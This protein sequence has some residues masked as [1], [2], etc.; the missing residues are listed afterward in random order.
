MYRQRHNPHSVTYMRLSTPVSG[1]AAAQYREAPQPF[2]LHIPVLPAYQLTRT[3]SLQ[4]SLPLHCPWCERII[5]CHVKRSLPPL[6]LS[7]PSLSPTHR[8][9]RLTLAL[10][11]LSMLSQHHTVYVQH[12]S[13]SASIKRARVTANHHI[14]CSHYCG[15]HRRELVASYQGNNTPATYN[16]IP[17]SPP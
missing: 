7:R 3:C 5:S 4:G 13:A 16:S 17:S 15:H 6:T 14:K 10:P 1:P 11:V 8:R 12:A 2:T 9:L